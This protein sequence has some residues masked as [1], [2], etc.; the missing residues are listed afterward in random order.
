MELTIDQALQQGIAAHKEG[1]LQD[2]ERLYRAI[3]QAQPKHPDANHNLGVLAVAAD[4]PLEAISLF[5]LA[6]ET[7]PQIEQFWLSYIDVLMRLERFDEA[8]RVVVEAKNFGDCSEK[9]ESYHH[10]I[11]TALPSKDQINDLMELYQFGRLAEAEVLASLFTQKF[12]K[13]HFGWKVL[14]VVYQQDGR[15]IDSFTPLKKS[16]ELSPRDPEA[17]FNLGTTLQALDRL[18]D[19]TKSY[20]KAIAIKPDY[21]AAHSNLGVALKALGKLEEAEASYRRAIAASPSY[22]DAY[23]NLCALLEL[24]NDI[25]ALLLV[26]ES[27][28]LNIESTSPDFL[29]FEAL[30]SFRKG[31]NEKAEKLMSR[32]EES[33]IGEERRAPY[34]KLKGDLYQQSADYDSAFSA[35]K[36]S[37]RVVKAGSEFQRV[38]V[39]ANLYFESHQNVVK[40]LETLS[41]QNP[42]SK[43]L[44]SHARQLTFLVGF[45]RSGTTLLDTI[46]RTHSRVQVIEEQPM[47]SRMRAVLGNLQEVTAIESIDKARLSVARNAYFEELNKHTDSLEE[48][49][50]VDKLPLNLLHAPLIHRIFPHANFIFSQRHPLDCILSCWMQNFKLNP[51]MANMVDLNRTVDF[52]CVAMEIFKLSQ[53]RYG[54]NVH[55]V[56]YEDLVEDFEME[57]ASLLDFLGLEWEAGILDYQATAA[58]RERI[59]TPSYSQVIKPIYKTASYRWRYYDKYLDEFKSKLMPWMKE[60]G[61]EA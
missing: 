29:Y 24:T 56:R 17:H 5:K 6:L 61:Y 19:A 3:L 57:V 4:K 51:A 26:L 18:E 40:Q 10:Q 12:P 47:V 13:H 9:L 39:M 44:R 36:N 53:R 31:Q 14:G 60:Y 25:G 37:N 50:L 20:E 15:L 42:R 23:I 59:N 27:A 48:S 46:L 38:K 55:S 32:I 7:N 35:Y 1:K 22:A 34:F 21:A 30:A 2:A 54:L 58:E 45:P 43:A 33:Q 16:V 28:R 8:A 41:T 49:I 11:Q 52:Y